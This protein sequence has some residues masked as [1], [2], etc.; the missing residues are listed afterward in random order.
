MTR[1]NLIDPE[2]LTD[3]HLIAERVELTMALSSA[4]RSLNSRSGLRIG[5]RYTLG[6]GHVIFFHNKIGYLKDRFYQL[7]DEMRNRGMVP[8]SPW[9]DDSWV[10]DDMWGGYIPTVEAIKEVKE[11]IRSRIL[12]KPEWYRYKK[13]P[14]TKEW[15]DEKYTP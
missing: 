8:K 10:R 3:Q 4:R 12:Q 15:I 6:S 14:I 2:M 11:R 1:V 5:E 13:Q 7:E 9:P